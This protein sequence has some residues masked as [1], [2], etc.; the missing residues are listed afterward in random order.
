M[1]PGESLSRAPLLSG[2]L[3]NKQRRY[4]I[5]QSKAIALYQKTA[6]AGCLASKRPPT[7]ARKLLYR[8]L[9]LPP[10]SSR[11]PL[12]TLELH[13][14]LGGSGS[15]LDPAP[16]SPLTKN[17]SGE[18][19]DIYISLSPSQ[20]NHTLLSDTG[21]RMPEII[22]QAEVCSVAGGATPPFVPETKKY[23][24]SWESKWSEACLCCFSDMWPYLF[25]YI[26]NN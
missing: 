24:V 13:H 12:H 15:I 14:K 10:S 11:P 22:T 7:K 9:K 8:L 3:M 25:W 21:I 1:N 5:S 18:T 2:A 23:L 20:V 26:N 17:P 19:K 16:M 6:A 4:R